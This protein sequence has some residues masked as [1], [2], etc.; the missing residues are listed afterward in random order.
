M[1]LGF[2]HRE[3]RA[4]AGAYRGRDDRD[5]GAM[6]AEEVE[7][8]RKALA[9]PTFGF[10]SYAAESTKL[11]EKELDEIAAR[12]RAGYRPDIVGGVQ[13]GLDEGFIR[14]IQRLL[15]EEVGPEMAFAR[16]VRAMEEPPKKGGPL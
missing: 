15:I 8:L 1:I 4:G 5:G 12:I 2:K 13:R 14:L 11:L 10:Y 16:L 9:E 3:R 6:T 7:L